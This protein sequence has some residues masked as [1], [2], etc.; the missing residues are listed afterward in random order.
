MSGLLEELQ[1]AQRRQSEKLETIHGAVQSLKELIEARDDKYD[2][3]AKIFGISSKAANARIMRDPEL[4]K[5]GLQVGKSVLF[6][7]AAVEAY[8]AAKAGR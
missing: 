1:E 7:R 3:L 6:K 5:I 8:Y 4:R 2:P